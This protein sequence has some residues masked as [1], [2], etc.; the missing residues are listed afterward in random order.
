[1]PGT[2]DHLGAT[3]LHRGCDSDGFAG[4]L[5]V[6]LAGESEDRHRDFTQAS[7]KVGLR[8]GAREAKR[9]GEA[10]AVA[11][12]RR[13]IR[14]VAEGGEEGLGEPLVEKGVDAT[15]LDATSELLVARAARGAFVLVDDA[16]RRAHQ[17]EALYDVGVGEGHVEGDAPPHGVP[18]QVDRLTEGLGH[19]SRRLVEVRSHVGRFAVAGQVECQDLVATCQ[20]GAVLVGRGSR[21]G[22]AVEPREGRAS[23]VAVDAEE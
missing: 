3:V 1:M 19:E 23:A 22:K 6:A 8:A 16:P 2:F 9:R 4:K 15:G 14:G 17:D 18:P 13:E 5:L 7:V 20:N 10:R 11:A 12:P 21:L